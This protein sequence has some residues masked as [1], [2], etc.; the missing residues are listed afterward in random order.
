M[1]KRVYELMIL[2]RPV[3]EATY[4]E[5][6]DWVVETIKKFG[7]ELLEEPDKWGKRK[8]AY[9]IS[10]P[11]EKGKKYWEGY[12]TVFLFTLPVEAL[13]EL[14]HLLKVHRDVLRFMLLRKERLEKELQKKQQSSEGAGEQ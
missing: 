8:L 13:E 5:I 12:Y 4:E 3:E 2:V 11:V 7:G 1:D 14:K 9:R 10:D 6:N